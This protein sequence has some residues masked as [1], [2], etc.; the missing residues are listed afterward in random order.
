MEINDHS[1]A[2][3]KQT[4]KTLR[5][6]FDMHSMGMINCTGQQQHWGIL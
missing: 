4:A 5:N 6:A 3:N 2:I 1:H